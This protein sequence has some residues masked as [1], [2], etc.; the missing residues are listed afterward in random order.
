M[1]SFEI[2]NQLSFNTFKQ[3]RQTCLVIAANCCTCSENGATLW[4]VRQNIR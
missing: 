4:S 3:I 2:N 1:K